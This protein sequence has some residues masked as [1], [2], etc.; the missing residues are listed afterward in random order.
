MPF[1]KIILI[2]NITKLSH[3][4]ESVLDIHILNAKNKT[5]FPKEVE[6][7]KSGIRYASRQWICDELELSLA[8]YASTED[9]LKSAKRQTRF[10]LLKCGKK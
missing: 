8:H 9:M 10:E 7:S 4:F 2:G 5:K 1:G 3:D 6:I